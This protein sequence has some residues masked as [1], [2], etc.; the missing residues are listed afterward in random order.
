LDVLVKAHE[1]IA[2]QCVWRV[3]FLSAPASRGPSLL[4]VSKLVI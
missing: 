1:Q 3:I 2:P 4:V